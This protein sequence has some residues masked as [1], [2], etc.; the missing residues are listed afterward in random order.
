MNKSTSKYSVANIGYDGDNST[1]D[2]KNRDARA[3]FK[4]ESALVEQ[5]LSNVHSTS[6]LKAEKP[7]QSAS[8][9][10]S[11]NIGIVEDNRHA[12]IR[13]H[14]REEGALVSQ[15]LAT[16]HPSRK[17]SFV[18]R[19]YPETAKKLSN[20]L[21]ENM[22]KQ[23]VQSYQT[24]NTN[25]SDIFNLKQK[26]EVNTIARNI[27]SEHHVNE[28]KM[29]YNQNVGCQATVYQAMTGRTAMPKDYLYPQK[30][31]H[32]QILSLTNSLKMPDPFKNPPEV[33]RPKK[34][35]GDDHGWE[36]R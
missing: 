14:Y 3:H 23:P 15:H 12:P 27:Q 18:N 16:E 36:D 29:R 22:N 21:K 33:S 34:W 13:S 2:I 35:L 24:K 17:V 25:N 1:N 7:L 9:Y 26:E 11:T 10:S 19:Q 4:K 31:S 5:H 32:Q 28:R 8:R 6:K 20:C 30:A